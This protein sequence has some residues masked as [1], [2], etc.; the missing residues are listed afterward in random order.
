ML[1]INIPVYNILV[2]DLVGQLKQQAKKISNDFEIIVYDDGSSENFKLEN[3]KLADI[4]Q[5]FYWEME[6]NQGR[7]A[8]RNKMG[9]ESQKPYL[10]FI[11]ADSKL[12]SDD[13]L[14]KYVE[15]AKPGVV[16]CGG[17][18]YSAI[19]PEGK[20][21]LRWVYGTR[22]EAISAEERN[23]K[24]GFIITSNNFLIDRETFKKIHFRE[25]IGPY[26]H[27]DTLL[28]FDLFQSGIKPEHINNPVEHTGLEDSL[29]FLNKTK[30]ALENLL[31]ISEKILPETSEFKHR[32]PFLNRYHKITRI[33]PPFLIA[34]FFNLFRQP[35]EK[36]LTGKNPSLVWFDFYKLGYF[37]SLRKKQPEI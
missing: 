8:I 11:D 26:G 15:L 37:A 4:P 36:N 32:M 9:L 21:L 29:T 35:I 22:R 20:K 30:A 5:V 3:R 13:F 14:K 28:G 1:S 23:N 16:L 12:I 31:I 7:A 18:S 34:W 10:L 2:T 33:I 6:K 19:K 27:E 17:T 25:D 24:K